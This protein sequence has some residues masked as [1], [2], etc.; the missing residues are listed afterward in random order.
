MRRFVPIPAQPRSVAQ[1]EQDKEVGV[2]YCAAQLL[3]I[4]HDNHANKCYDK[5]C[6]DSK[7]TQYWN[8]PTRLELQTAIKAL[9]RAL[10]EQYRA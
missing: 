2:Q 6:V 10:E 7:H 3:R 9:Q 1:F 4:L 5:H 8:D